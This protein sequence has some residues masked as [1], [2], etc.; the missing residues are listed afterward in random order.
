M[1]ADPPHIM[2]RLRNNILDNGVTTQRGGRVDR[3]L[4][5]ELLAIDGNAELRILHKL[6]LT[7]HVEV[8]GIPVPVM[9]VFGCMHM[10]VLLKCCNLP[11]I[12]Y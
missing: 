10:L 4:M 1:M 11:K 12:K 3:A 2:K 8:S 6:H 5:E 7:S 9:H